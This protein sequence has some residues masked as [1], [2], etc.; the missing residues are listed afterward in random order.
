M[1][2]S[3]SNSRSTFLDLPRG[4][5]LP[6][7]AR[8]AILPLAYESTVTYGKGA[9]QGPGAIIDASAHIES[10][11]EELGYEP[12]EAGI[13]TLDGPQI[14]GLAPEEMIVRV[15]ESVGGA[16]ER[17]R[18]LICLGGEHS[19]TVPAV[20]ATRDAM[21][22]FHVLQIDAH[23]N[24]RDT[25]NGTRYSQACT[26]A[27]VHEMGPAITQ[28]GIRSRSKEDGALLD[29]PDIR[30]FWMHDLRRLPVAEWVY[31]IVQSLG[32]RVYLTFDVDALDSGLMP[33]TGMPEPGGLRW[34]ET[35]ELLSAVASQRE[36]I[37]SDFV[38][39]APIAGMHAPDHAVARLI[40]KWIGFLED[41]R[42]RAG[43]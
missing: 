20:A 35:L 41:A 32:P 10:L 9:A 34:Y 43:S 31:D 39:L 14:E 27:R 2:K 3:D 29:S 17:G 1:G 8:Y 19:I 4:I 15:R 37:G 40:Y 21:G 23:A 13:A 25:H 30:T 33:A 42:R 7:G 22:D 5:A 28:V 12:C 24:L 6:G 38:E 16:I 36:V 18:H 26:M 11:D